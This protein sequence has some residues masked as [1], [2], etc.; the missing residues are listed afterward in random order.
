LEIS[1]NI[2]KINDL[3]RPV[4]LSETLLE[5]NDL[6]KALRKA[7]LEINELQMDDSRLGAAQ[8]TVPAHAAP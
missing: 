7:T 6:R 8:F 4:K 5:I 3:R 2:V 1:A